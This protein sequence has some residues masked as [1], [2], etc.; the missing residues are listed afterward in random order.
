MTTSFLLFLAAAS[1]SSGTHPKSFVVATYKS[2]MLGCG[3]MCLRVASTGRNIVG[4]LFVGHTS[5]RLTQPSDQLPRELECILHFFLFSCCWLPFSA[6][7]FSHPRKHLFASLAVFVADS[8]V[9]FS[10]L[11][12]FSYIIVLR[13]LLGSLWMGSTAMLYT[14]DSSLK[15]HGSSFTGLVNSN[16]MYCIITYIV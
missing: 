12:H 8:R 9:L 1:L 11:H 16:L 4:S 3:V 14:C 13:F 15:L 10:L 6:Q 5:N 2:S 7:N